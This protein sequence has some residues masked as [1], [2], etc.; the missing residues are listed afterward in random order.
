MVGG[1]QS[2]SFTFT[3]DTAPAFI[4]LLIQKRNI[5]KINLY[6]LNKPKF[7][8]KLRRSLN[9]TGE[10]MKNGKQININLLNS[11]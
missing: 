11:F 6:T 2:I 9:S 8:H 10:I 4:F 7:F 5:K 1:R 3:W